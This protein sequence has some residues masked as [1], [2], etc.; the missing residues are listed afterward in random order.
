MVS[1][2]KMRMDWGIWLAIAIIAM[3]VLYVA[4]FPLACSLVR[5][6]SMPFESAKIIYRPLVWTLNWTRSECVHDQLDWLSGDA[7]PD[8]GI[9]TYLGRPTMLLR[10]AISYE[11]DRE[12]AELAMEAKGK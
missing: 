10:F 2:K 7:G 3:P 5:R 8:S 4:S 1:P 6:K 11:L 9:Y 12:E